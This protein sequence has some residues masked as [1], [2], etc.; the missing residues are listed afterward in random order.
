MDQGWLRWPEIQFQI[1]SVLSVK[2]RKVD[3][4]EHVF[5]SRDQPFSTYAKCSEK[6]TPLM[7]TLILC[8]V[9]QCIV[10]NKVK[11]RIS[12]RVFQENKARQIFR[13]TN[14]S[15]PLIRIRT[16]VCVSG[17]KKCSFFENFGVLCF[18]ETPV[19]RF[20]YLPYCRRY[21]NVLVLLKPLF[22]NNISSYL[23]VYMAITY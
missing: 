22:Q 12:K 21:M 18:L 7:P 5:K 11:G 17:G 13:E 16:Y 15:Y 9:V 1:T 8:D 2:N 19:L 23:L 6:L 4:A 10:G 14:I 3:L 20:A